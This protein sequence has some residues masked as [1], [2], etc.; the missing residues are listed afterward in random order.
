M[1]SIPVGK[2]LFLLQLGLNDENM[3]VV[4]HVF[5]TCV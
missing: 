4:T 3:T 5:D 1:N 2:M